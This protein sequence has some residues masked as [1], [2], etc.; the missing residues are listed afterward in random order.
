MAATST[1]EAPWFVVPAD[2]KK[3][4]RLVI[5]RIVNQTLESM[6]LKYP[7]LDKQRRVELNASRNLL[8]RLK[9]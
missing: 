4:A 5:S 9:P 3:N 8:T 2:D 7:K 1:Q 6:G